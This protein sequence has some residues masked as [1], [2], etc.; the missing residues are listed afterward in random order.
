M[1]RRLALAFVALVVAVVALYGGPRYLALKDY[2]TDTERASVDRGADASAELARLALSEDRP[3]TPDLLGPLLGPGERVEY[4]DGSGEGFSVPSDAARASGD[5]V[6]TRALPDGATV[7]YSVSGS[8]LEQRIAEAV[9]PLAL[10]GLL[11]IP[12]GLVAG[13]L[14]ARRLSRPFAELAEAAH[15]MGSGDL[16]REVP[17][18]DV[19]EADEI[20]T[21]LRDSAGRLHEM[22]ERERDVATHASHELRTPITALRLA[23]EDVSMWPGTPPDVTEELERLVGEVDRLA[24]AVTTLLDARR[25]WSDPAPALDEDI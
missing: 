16:T 19:R 23:L 11:L 20:A 4:R 18:Y 9:A 2:V 17:S 6:A 7:T 5:L 12:V 1:V 15:A 10:L 22:L 14:L 24:E 25:R 21:A 8:T 13:V 3:V